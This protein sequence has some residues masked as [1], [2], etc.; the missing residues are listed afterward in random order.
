MDKL[1]TLSTGRRGPGLTRCLNRTLPLDRGSCFYP[2]THSPQD[3]KDGAQGPPGT[4]EQGC[5]A[6][7]F[8]GLEEIDTRFDLGPV[9]TL[10]LRCSFHHELEQL[11]GNDVMVVY[12]AES[13]L[14]QDMPTAF[15]KEKLLPL[16]QPWGE[17]S[18]SLGGQHLK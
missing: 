6:H 11:D 5:S 13:G 3:Q 8:G 12:R 17:Q 1:R 4:G 18:L 14:P 16:P 9:N 15:P 2:Q 10:L 7:T